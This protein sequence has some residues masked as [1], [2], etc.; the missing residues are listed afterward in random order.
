MAENR[1]V[2]ADELRIC[3]QLVQ[4]T[5]N[6][7]GLIRISH[8]R[9]KITERQTILFAHVL[10]A[11]RIAESCILLAQDEALEDLWTISRSFSELVINCGYLHIATDQEVTNYIYF[12]GHKVTSQATKLMSHRPPEISP[13]QELVE[14]INSLASSSRVLTGL[15]D[16]KSTWSK[17]NLAARAQETDKHFDTKEF[18][19]LYLAA[20][21]YGNAGTH[22]TMLSLWWS[23]NELA[24]G[25]GEQKDKRMSMLA[26]AMH[27]SV[28]ALNL[29]C[30]T[31]NEKYNLDMRRE[32]L[33][34]C[35]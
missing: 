18:Y 28:L 33:A 31:L 34:A 21:P 5:S 22:N 30:M 17:F 12:D 13:S 2:L 10:R 24:A 9:I 1:F 15:D 8:S 7:L 27:T 23:V 25:Q 29:L 4:M 14:S 6:L 20:A 3:R 26:G 11:R 16:N 19:T 32:I 35:R